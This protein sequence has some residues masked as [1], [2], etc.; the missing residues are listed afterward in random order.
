[1][2]DLF[3]IIV[4]V[5]NRAYCLERTFMSIYNQGYRPLELI[6]VD[7][8]SSDGS[9]EMCCGLQKQFSS[10]DFSIQ[11][12]REDKQ[13]VCAARNLGAK[14]AHGAYLYFFDSD[15]EMSVDYLQ[16][17]NDILNKN[18]LCDCVAV[19]TVMVFENGRCVLRKST[20]T[21][22][23]SDQILTGMLSTQSMLMRKGFF[24]K[25]GMWNEDLPRWNDWEL[26]VRCLLHR[27]VLVWSDRC[28]HRIYQHVNS[29]TG[30][31]FAADVELL[32]L[33]IDHVERL[34]K[35]PQCDNVSRQRAINALLARRILLAAL[36]HR[37]GALTDSK[38]LYAASLRRSNSFLFRQFLR[39]LYCY[40][41]AGGIGGWKIARFFI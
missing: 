23:V 35:A 10:T 15:D 3:S 41:C 16:Q 5:H 28:Y 39:L 22:E 37:E 4:P 17:M 18:P 29:I 2:M 27:P 36:C 8:N 26:G 1:M 34:I 31:G 12:L 7:N 38:R 24:F 30:K 9:W 11:V 40:Q 14:S 21:T 20:F 19:R 33:A 32:T 13:G 6:L 25:I